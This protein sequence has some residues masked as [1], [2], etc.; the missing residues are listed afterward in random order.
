[1]SRAEQG[2]PND[3]WLMFYRGSLLR[4]RGH[5]S[6]ASLLLRRLISGQPNNY[7]AYLVLARRVMIMGRPDDAISLL[8][9]SASLDPP[10]AARR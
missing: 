4:A 7:A 6:E 5:W 9:K 8:K 10:D 1:M 3:E 2:K